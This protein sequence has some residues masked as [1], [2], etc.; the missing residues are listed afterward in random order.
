MIRSLSRSAV[1]ALVALAATG[2]ISVAQAQFVV[3]PFLS[4]TN[5]RNALSPTGIGASGG[6]Y[7]G[8]VGLRF[9]G[10]VVLDQKDRLDAATARGWDTDFD[11][12]L[13]LASPHA[14]AGL[15]LVPFAFVGAGSHGRPDSTGTYSYGYG[16]MGG[17]TYP[18]QSGSTT[19]AVDSRSYG[20]GVN[21]MLGGNLELTGEA[22]W[23][24]LRT[25]TS[26]TTY[27][28]RSAGP[29]EMRLGLAIRL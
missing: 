10:S 22:R 21:L 23:R 11:I 2:G 26:S 28:W 12:V 18:Q 8:P 25:P 24:Y 27:D 14:N 5:A 9:G 15:A 17:I 19:V 29:S 3:S 13:R 1:G 20:G 4:Y 7:F 16:S 6:Y